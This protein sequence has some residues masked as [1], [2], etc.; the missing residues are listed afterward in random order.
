MRLYLMRHGP[1]E[2]RSATGR[3]FDRRLTPAGRALVRAMG[4]ALLRER[5][6]ATGAGASSVG[7]S[8]RGEAIRVVSSPLVRARE[9]AEIVRE[10]LGAGSSALE[11]EEALSGDQPIPRALVAAL[12]GAGRDALVV[13]HQP[14][15]EDLT[16]VLIQPAPL[17]LR[18]FPTATIVTLA[19]EGAGFAVVSVLDPKAVRP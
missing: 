2:D 8:P 18:G 15:I 13:G 1:A 7:S 14:S 17:A 19:V 10:A 5:T 6:G 11:I 12:V 4:E 3:D 16:R 9:T